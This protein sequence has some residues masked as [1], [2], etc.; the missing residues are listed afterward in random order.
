MIIC[1][2]IPYDY[3]GSPLITSRSIG[4]VIRIFGNFLTDSVYLGVSSPIE[5]H[6]VYRANIYGSSL[7]VA[8]AFLKD[9]KL[10]IGTDFRKED[11]EGELNAKDLST[12]VEYENP[13]AAG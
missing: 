7:D 12:S 11:L 5:E 2:T 3:N 1:L 10:T 4:R 8:W 6:D 13:M 9:H